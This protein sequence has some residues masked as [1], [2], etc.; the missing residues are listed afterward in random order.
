MIKPWENIENAI[1]KENSWASFRMDTIAYKGFYNLEGKD[2]DGMILFAQYKTIDG[3]SAALEL[4]LSSA[5]RE[6][7]KDKL[8]GKYL[9]EI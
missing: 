6:D 7:L 9:S 2:V 1:I 8:Q 3:C 5:D 4:A